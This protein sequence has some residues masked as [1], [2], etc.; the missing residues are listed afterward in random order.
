MSIDDEEERMGSPTVL[1]IWLE[2]VIVVGTVELQGLCCESGVWATGGPG[3][4]EGAD[5][6]CTLTL[7]GGVVN[8]PR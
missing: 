7:A 4:V 5:S 3:R 2:Q 1:I 6:S 8:A